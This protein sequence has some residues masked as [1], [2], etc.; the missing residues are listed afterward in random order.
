MES[1]IPSE[2][3]SFKCTSC[4]SSFVSQNKLNK[5]ISTRHYTEDDKMHTCSECGKK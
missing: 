1:H 3:K 5:H 2:E 4:D